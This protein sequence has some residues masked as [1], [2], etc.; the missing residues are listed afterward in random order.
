MKKWG[1]VVLGLVLMLMSTAAVHGQDELSL[2]V[3]V[4]PWVTTGYSEFSL[5][6]LAVNPVSDLVWRG[7]DSVI[8]EVTGE[9]RWRRVLLMGAVGLGGLRDGA[10]L[11]DDFLLDRRRGRFSHTRSVVDGGGV[12]YGTVDVGARVLAW[13]TSTWTGA[14]DAFVGYQYWQ[15]Q[16]EAFGLKGALA[17]GGVSL[18]NSTKVLTHDYRWKALRVGGRAHV[19]LIG[20]LTATAKAVWLPLGWW[21]WEDVHH[22]RPD[23]RQN[24]SVSAKSDR[25]FGWELDLGLMYPL[26]RGLSAGAG[27][28]YWAMDSE[29]GTAQFRT[30]TETLPMKVRD[31]TS[32]RHGPYVGLQYRF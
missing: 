21:E 23:L 26:W 5:N 10:F 20:G 16:Y 11:D 8:T 28:R 4:R 32:E 9:V 19:G 22:L 27:Y 1:S 3:G 14:V 24:P 30:L 29:G 7:T 25:A 6:N 2:T 12:F 18:P 15:E 13:N 17:S 31:A